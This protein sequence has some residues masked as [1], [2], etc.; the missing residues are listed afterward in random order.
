MALIHGD[1]TSLEK[2]SLLSLGSVLCARVSHSGMRIGNTP[3]EKYCGGAVCSVSK[4][5]NFCLN[6]P[7]SRLVRVILRLLV[8]LRLG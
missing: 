7:D 8:F 5:C 6:D 4:F 2:V 3:A 1:T